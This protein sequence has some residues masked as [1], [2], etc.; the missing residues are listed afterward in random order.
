VHLG[1]MMFTCGECDKAFSF[2]SN[3]QT[4]RRAVHLKEKPFKCSTCGLTFSGNGDLKRH[5]DSIHLGLRPHLCKECGS[6]FPQLSHLKGHIKS[7]HTSEAPRYACTHPGCLSTYATLRGLKHHHMDHTGLRPFPCP[8]ASCDERFKSQCKVNRHIKNAK[9]HAGHRLA[10]KFIDKHLLPFTC[11]V[12]GCV[13]RYETE[14]E[15]D[16]HMEKLH[17]KD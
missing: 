2:R 4:H 9:K 11:Q 12:E 8:Y 10:S 13:N 5:T 14:V 1:E 6:S 7:M 16:R 17:P 3:L 15:R